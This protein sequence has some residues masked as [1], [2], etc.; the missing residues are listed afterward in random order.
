MMIAIIPGGGYFG[1]EKNKREWLRETRVRYNNKGSSN[2][3]F[4]TEGGG[5]MR[6]AII[7]IVGVTGVGTHAKRGG[8]GGI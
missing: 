5:G 3:N 2:G 8:D 7:T 1:S 6:K 4:V